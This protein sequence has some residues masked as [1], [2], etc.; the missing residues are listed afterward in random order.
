MDLNESI[1]EI[2]KSENIRKN[3]H[4]INYYILKGIYS[5]KFYKR[6]KYF[7]DALLKVYDSFSNNIDISIFDESQIIK[8][9]HQRFSIVNNLLFRLSWFLRV[10]TR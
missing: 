9:I 6:S 10:N 8:T 4:P 5:K 1:I 7:I 3:I 2:L